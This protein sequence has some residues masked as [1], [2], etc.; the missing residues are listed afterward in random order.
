MDDLEKAPDYPYGAI[1]VGVR[2]WRI[3]NTRWALLGGYLW[4]AAMLDCWRKN[5]EWKEAECD[6]HIAIPDEHCICGIWGFFNPE[7]LYRELSPLS[8]HHPESGSVDGIIGVTGGIVLH[9]DG[10]RAQYAKVLGIFEDDHDTPKDEIAAMYHVPILDPRD[11]DT[12][13]D[14]RGLIRLDP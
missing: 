12:F 3:A 14:K 2:R 10:F 11:F 8:Y 5:V 13:C 1:G 7:I 6:R 9:E 4:S